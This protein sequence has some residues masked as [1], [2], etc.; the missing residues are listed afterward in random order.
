MAGV[1]EGEWCTCGPRVTVNG[2]PYPPAA[3]FEVPGLSWISSF[4]GGAEKEKTKK[5]GADGKGEL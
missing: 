2:K 3:K 4:F 5:D 1:P